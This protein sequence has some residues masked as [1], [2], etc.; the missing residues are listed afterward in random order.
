MSRRTKSLLVMI[1]LVFGSLGFVLN[2][3]G[4]AGAVALPEVAA[5][6]AAPA[7]ASTPSFTVALSAEPDSLDP[8][9]TFDANA[10]LV[11]TQI[12]E[13]L[14]ALA[15]NDLSPRPGLAD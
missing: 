14:I 4:S 15:P 13:T 12:Y 3:A 11:G 5:P 7:L 9:L 2:V 10:F 1:G 8:A 6:S